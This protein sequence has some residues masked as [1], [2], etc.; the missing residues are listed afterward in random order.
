MMSFQ[1]LRFTTASIVLMLTRYFLPS[2]SR[3]WPG[4]VSQ[5]RRI[6][7][8]ISG[9]SLCF[10]PFECCCW[11]C[12]FCRIPFSLRGDLRTR[13]IPETR[14]KQNQGN[15]SLFAPLS[16]ILPSASNKGTTD[17][18]SPLLSLMPFGPELA[19]SSSQWILTCKKV[20]R[21][22]TLVGFAGDPAHTLCWN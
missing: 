1:I 21:E 16:A 12:E 17:S 18:D 15:H 10:F 2:E 3:F 6:L 9:S 22:R 19:M 11:S 7:R 14:L 8:T 13:S 20:D 4:L 5:S